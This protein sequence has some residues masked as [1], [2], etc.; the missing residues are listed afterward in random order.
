MKYQ[1]TRE[2]DFKIS[3]V[4]Y[5]SVAFKPQNSARTILLIFVTA[6]GTLI[7]CFSAFDN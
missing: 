1:E 6:T 5:Y 7:L 3:F 4:T 2:D